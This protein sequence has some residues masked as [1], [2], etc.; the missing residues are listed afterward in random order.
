MT[1]DIDPAGDYHWDL[2]PDG[3]HLA[4]LNAADHEADIR[5][6]PIAGGTGQDVKVKGW[7]ALHSLDWAAD[8]KGFFASTPSGRGAKLLHIDLQGRAQAIWT[9]TVGHQTWGA[10]SPDGK[11]L[12][13]L[14][15]TIVSNVWMIENF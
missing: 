8:G 7:D 1:I 3:S 14:G 11:K 15:L 2:S 12:A 4:I 9:Q 5:I 10:P 6:L 13:I